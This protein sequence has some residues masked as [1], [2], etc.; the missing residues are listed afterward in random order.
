M[1]NPKPR[2]DDLIRQKHLRRRGR[3]RCQWSPRLRRH[4]LGDAMPRPYPLSRGKVITPLAR[5]LID[6]GANTHL[7]SIGET[8]R[9]VNVSGKLAFATTSGANISILAPDLVRLG[10]PIASFWIPRKGV[11]VG[12]CNHVVGG[13]FFR[14]L[15][16]HFS[17]TRGLPFAFTL[18]RIYIFRYI[19]RVNES[20]K[21]PLC[22]H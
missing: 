9:N 14:S 6:M 3:G 17:F 1:I 15:F 11:S 20:Q 7:I 18:A 2:G 10:H 4:A 16:V 8:R 13:W 5:R 12:R 21:R 22:D 19:R